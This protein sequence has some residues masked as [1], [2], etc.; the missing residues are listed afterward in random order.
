MKILFTGGGTAGHIFP[1]I[2]VAREIRKVYQTPKRMVAETS[3]FSRLASGSTNEVQ[4]TDDL[5]FFYVGPRDEFSEGLLSQEGF[6]VKTILAGKI[7]RYFGFKAFF[8]NIFDIFFK[9]PA[10]FFQGFFHVYLISPDLIFSKGGYGSLSVVFCGWMLLVPIFLHESDIIPGFTNRLLS[11]LSLE[12]F[13]SFP[14]EKTQYFPFKKMISVGNPIRTEI[15]E[16]NK[17][18]AKTLFKLTGEKPVILI[19]GGSQ[20]SKKINDVLLTILPEI[21]QNFEVIHQV[22]FKNLKEIEAE[23][24][25]II[26]IN[27][28]KYYHLFSFL[29]E[30]ELK[31]A[32]AAADLIVSRAGSGSIFEISAVGKPSIL[33]PL[34]KAAQNHQV[35]NAYVYAESGSCLVIEEVNLKPHFFLERLKYLF[36]ESDKLKEMAESAGV[37]SRPQAGKII[38][39]YL[40][41]YLGEENKSSLTPFTAARVTNENEP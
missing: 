15:L 33:I 39:R 37:F 20:G 13:V 41:E 35:K 24:K 7:R 21:L 16:G 34:P 4:R 9:I 19:L 3:F 10:G 17:E 14:I 30:E 11:K 12:I 8:Q 31:E 29:T 28:Q 5:Q 1:I 27:L 26:Q 40:V 36:S 22:G 23:V 6:V 25:A 18:K 32:Y 2:A 38:A